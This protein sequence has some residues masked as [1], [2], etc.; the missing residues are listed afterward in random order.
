[1]IE[2]YDHASLSKLSEE[3]DRPLKSLYALSLINDPFM[4]G[5]PFR[6]AKAEWFAADLAA[7]RIQAG[8][9]IRRVI[10]C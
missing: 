1:M 7:V 5:I 8:S 3:L 2:R 9:H 10:T 6:K 4:A